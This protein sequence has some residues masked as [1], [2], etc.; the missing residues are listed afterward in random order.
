[1][2]QKANKEPKDKR[3]NHHNPRENKAMDKEEAQQRVDK[4]KD[5]AGNQERE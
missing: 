4:T 2:R 1:M 5:Q 3:G